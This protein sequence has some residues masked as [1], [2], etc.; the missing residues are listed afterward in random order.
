MKMIECKNC[1][2]ILIKLEKDSFLKKYKTLKNQL[3]HKRHKWQG[4][5]PFRECHC[6]CKNP[7]DLDN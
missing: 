7:E 2:H 1:G 5:T 4:F 6:G 3:C